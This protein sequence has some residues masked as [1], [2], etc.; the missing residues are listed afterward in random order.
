M[1]YEMWDN[2]PRE[3]I[4]YL[5]SHIAHPTSVIQYLP[6]GV[7]QG[8]ELVEPF[9]ICDLEFIVPHYFITARNLSELS[10]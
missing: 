9:D 2:K 8:G 1:R 10:D 3:T 7:A 6:F 5:S 4:V